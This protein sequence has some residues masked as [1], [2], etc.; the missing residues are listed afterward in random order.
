MP[1]PLRRRTLVRYWCSYVKSARHGD[2]IAGYFTATAADGWRNVLVCCRAPD[3]QAWLEPLGKL[4]VEIVYHPRA[5][6]NFDPACIAR[7]FR[8]CREVRCQVFHCDNT[9]TSPLIGATLARVPARVWTKHAMEPA[10]ETGRRATLRDRV[11]LSLR[12]SCRLAH[13]VLA[14][15]QAVRQELLDKGI[16]PARVRTL[17][18]PGD[19]AFTSAPDVDR[20]AAR[21]RFGYRARDLVIAAIGRAVAVKG[22]DVLVSAFAAL[23]D[24]AACLVLVGQADSDPAFRARLDTLIRARGLTDRVRFTG[25]VTDIAA[26]LAASDIFVFPSRAEGFGLALVEALGAGLPVVSASVGGAPDLIA[27]GANGLLFPREDVDAL[28][29]RL[30]ALARDPVRRTALGAA[31]RRSPGLPGPLEH[32]HALLQVYRELLTKPQAGGRAATI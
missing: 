26:V 25:H 32:A 12:L 17:L 6:G 27:D 2:R 30:R 21:A 3:D 19:R 10:T 5:K 13:H 31:A 7:T 9:H 29:A 23:D 15:S 8:L 28:T 16:P 20:E 4:G 14:I 22:W 11:A 18:L 1:H 24:P